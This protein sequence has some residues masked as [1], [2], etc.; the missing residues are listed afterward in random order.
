MVRKILL[1]GYGINVGSAD[2]AVDLLM[3]ITVLLLLMPK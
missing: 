3:E 2:K 1:I